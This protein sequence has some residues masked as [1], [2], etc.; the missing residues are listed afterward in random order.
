MRL[1]LDE[2]L[3]RA[4][5]DRLID[6]GH[7][8]ETVH[9]QGM[10]GIEDGRLFEV[11]R[12]EGRALVT[13][14]VDFADPRRFDS[15]GTAGIAVLRA[16]SRPGRSHIDLVVDRLVD[17]LAARSIEDLLVIVEAHGVRRYAPPTSSDS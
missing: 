17:E 13:L 15:S 16:P 1:K 2:N 14:D 5:A 8:V 11:C 7:D 9:S 3:G 12:A 4:V 10:L 6:A